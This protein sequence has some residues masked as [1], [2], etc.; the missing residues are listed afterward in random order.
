MACDYRAAHLSPQ[1][2][3]NIADLQHQ[4]PN[5]RHV[6]SGQVFGGPD[7]GTA[8]W[9]PNWGVFKRAHPGHP[10]YDFPRQQTL[11]KHTLVPNP[12]LI[13]DRL[14]ETPAGELLSEDAFCTMPH[15][16]SH[17][18]VRVR[19]THGVHS[20]IAASPAPSL[21]LHRIP[22]SRGRS[23]HGVRYIMQ[24]AMGHSNFQRFPVP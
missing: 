16:M 7:S 9:S 10:A 1:N 5:S 3:I 19:C 23:L 15:A 4:T 18:S 20:W 21:A 13:L 14:T 8:I 6:K 12:R 2:V 17:E 24:A 11:L 22:S